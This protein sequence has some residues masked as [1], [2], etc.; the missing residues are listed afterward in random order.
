ML[1]SERTVPSNTITKSLLLCIKTCSFFLLQVPSALLCRASI[2]TEP[3]PTQKKRR[4]PTTPQLHSLHHLPRARPRLCTTTLSAATLFSTVQTCLHRAVVSGATARPHR[5]PW[6]QPTCREIQHQSTPR[7]L[8]FRHTCLHPRLLHGITTA[9]TTIITIPRRS[10][11]WAAVMAA[12]AP[13]S[14]RVSSM[15]R[16]A[17]RALSAVGDEFQPAAAGSQHS[18]KEAQQWRHPPRRLQHRQLQTTTLT[19][20]TLVWRWVVAKMEGDFN[21]KTVSAAK[22]TFI[23]ERTP[24]SLWFVRTVSYV[25]Q[26]F[27]KHSKCNAWPAPKILHLISFCNFL[28]CCKF[29]VDVY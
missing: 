9:V 26:V 29:I 14:Q 3:D 17:V 11:H 27:H 28:T 20:R 6:S 8:A 23:I 7:V 18:S 15:D 1:F 13:S 5:T 25:L 10:H 4:P 12:S 2:P 24:I 16:P 21:W 22:A 19:W